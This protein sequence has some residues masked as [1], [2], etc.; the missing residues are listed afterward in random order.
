MSFET[1]SNYGAGQFDYNAL[2]W[3]L[4][5]RKRNDCIVNSCLQCKNCLS[6]PIENN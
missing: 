4:K 5:N 6:I 2:Y 1:G 3:L